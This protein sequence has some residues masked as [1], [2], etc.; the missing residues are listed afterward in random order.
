M[1]L[2]ENLH[3]LQHLANSIPSPIFYK[4]IDG[5]YQGCNLALEKYLGKSK[6]EIVGKSVY[7]VFPVDLADKLRYGS[8]TIKRAGRSNLRVFYES[9]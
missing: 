9:R 3:F 4:G 1:A 7:D 5:I 6:E 2:S 8:S